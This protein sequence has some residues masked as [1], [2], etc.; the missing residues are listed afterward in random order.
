[1]FIK[2][3]NNVIGYKD[4]P[5]GFNVQFDEDKTYIV[6][7]NFQRKTTV[8]SLFNWCLTG[9]NLFGNEKEQV[10]NDKVKVSNVIVD[11]TFIDNLGI[12]HRLVRDKGKQMNLILDGKEIEQGMLAQFFKDKDIFLVAH[13]PYYFASLEPRDQKELIRK[14]IPAVSKEDIFKL[15]S[16]DEKNIIGGPIEFLGSYIDR[17]N[18]EINELQKEYEENSGKLQAYKDIVLR[19][20]DG[21]II[22]FEEEEK[23]NDL[24]QKYEDISLNLGSANLDNLQHIISRLD[25]RL[26]EIFKEKLTN[27]TELYNR[28]NEKLKNVDKE[29]SICPTCRQEIKDSEVKEHLKKFYQKELNRLQDKANNLK[30]EAK[31]LVSARKEKQEIFDKLNT[32][33]M[34]DLQEKRE[35]M[36][37]EIEALQAKKKDIMLANKQVE[38]MQEQL[39][40]AKQKIEETKEINQEILAELE[41]TKKQKEVAN[42]LKRLAIEQQ[43]HQINKYLDKVNIEFC[44]ENKTND[45][46]TEC[47][48]IY[49]EGREYK[50][51]SKS[52]QAR[53]CLEIS[54]LFNNLSGIKAPIF[55]DDAESITDI[56]EISN[57]QMIISVVI[58]YNPLEILYD[59]SEV[60]DRKKQSLERE[61]FEKDDFIIEKA[62]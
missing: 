59:Y 12:E 16:D 17:K 42:K 2:S 11:I 25:E 30:E 3:I 52:Q 35:K 51:L 23:L 28:E 32:T 21:N 44:R 18:E 8:G 36:K 33:D 43:R 4:L 1:M 24:L 9:T 22:H 29:K 50:K 38:V 5:D 6:G 40:N 53:A 49:Y 48:D 26:N 60:L 41:N 58:K 20:T 37:Q 19:Q 39:N 56:K 10:A 47:C 45:K 15:L 55:L 27:I 61:L 14:I 46:I 31:E 13:N 62:A 57:T 54:N 34:K 7:A